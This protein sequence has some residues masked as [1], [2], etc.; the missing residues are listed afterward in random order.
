MMVILLGSLIAL[1]ILGFPEA[2]QPFA[3]VE[4]AF[5]DGSVAGF[6]IVP[7]SCPSNPHTT[8]DCTTCTPE[9]ICIGSDRYYRNSDCSERFVE[10]CQYGCTNGQCIEPPEC[11]IGDPDCESVCSPD[12]FCSGDDLYFR[13]SSCTENFVRTCAA[14]CTNRA[15]NEVPSNPTSLDIQASPSVVRQGETTTVSWTSTRMAS[16][17][18]TE[19][20]PYIT[21]TWDGTTGSELSGEITQQTTYTLACIDALGNTLTDTARVNILPAWEED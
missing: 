15:C 6:Q 17:E 18:V 4:T 16:C 2:R 19:N 13:D 8:S 14:G 3:S 12:Y 10:T 11:E 21:D 20:N 7:A 9:F 1:A 5:T